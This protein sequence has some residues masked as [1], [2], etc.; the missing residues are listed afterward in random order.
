MGE[1]TGKLEVRYADGAGGVGAGYKARG[2]VWW[3]WVPPEDGV[4]ARAREPY[5]THAQTRGV[6]GAKR[7]GVRVIRDQLG[8]AGR[9]RSNAVD[10]EAEVGKGG[11]DVAIKV[12]AVAAIGA[13][14]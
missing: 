11:V 3:E 4:E 2:D 12:E 14:G 8:K 10:K 13:E 1:G 6:A 9:A 7:C 5:A